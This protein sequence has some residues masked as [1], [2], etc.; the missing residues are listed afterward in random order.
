MLCYTTCYSN[1]FGPSAMQ[2]GR[3]GSNASTCNN[4]L[5]IVYDRL[6]IDVEE[7]GNLFPCVSYWMGSDPCSDVRKDL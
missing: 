4:S 6:N 1:I 2:S 5:N 3:S 7:V